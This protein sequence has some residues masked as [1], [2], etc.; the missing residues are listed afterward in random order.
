[1]TDGQGNWCE[2]HDPAP[3]QWK[4]LMPKFVHRGTGIQCLCDE[5]RDRKLKLHRV[6]GYD[7]GFGGYLCICLGGRFSARSGC[8]GS[9][10]EE[11]G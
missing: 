5:R 3:P 4:Q 6:S 8:M 9:G 7:D 2:E 10:Y 1:M 11:E